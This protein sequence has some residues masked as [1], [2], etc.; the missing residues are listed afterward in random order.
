MANH[1]ATAARKDNWYAHGIGEPTVCLKGM[2][3]SEEHRRA[4]ET[5]TAD[6]LCHRDY[7]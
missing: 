2:E 4:H 6:T 1:F 7:A 5:E 3:S